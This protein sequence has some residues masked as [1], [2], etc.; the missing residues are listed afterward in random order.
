MPRKLR[1]NKKKKNKKIKKN[2]KHAKAEIIPIDASNFSGTNNESGSIDDFFENT[3][4]SPIEQFRSRSRRLLS[5]GNGRII[6]SR[7]ETKTTAPVVATM[8]P[9]IEMSVLPSRNYQRAPQ[10]A[11][12]RSIDLVQQE[13]DLFAAGSNF[14]V[15][16]TMG[17][18][19][20]RTPN[21]TPNRH[22]LRPPP[23]GSST[24][25]L[26]AY[27]QRR[28]STSGD[29]PSRPLTLPSMPNIGGSSIRNPERVANLA[30][31]LN[32]NTPRQAA[33]NRRRRSTIAEDD[34]LLSSAF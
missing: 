17:R 1:K 25:A 7:G 9:E 34:T 8:L 31:F 33:N 26:S 19:P 3:T 24:A 6:E 27:H 15:N 30:S 21:R 13:E 16:P 11:P 5:V 29:R 10:R 14:M 2:K 20:N 28:R 32:N 22:S 18:I 4:L 12:Q 23:S